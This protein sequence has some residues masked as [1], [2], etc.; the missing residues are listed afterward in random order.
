MGVFPT[1]YIHFDGMD[2]LLCVVEGRKTVHLYAPA[3]LSMYPQQEDG[4]T[5]KSA[6]ATSQQAELHQTFP[7][8]PVR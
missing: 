7:L 1:S 3:L 6:V 8:F 2:N 5:H 4:A